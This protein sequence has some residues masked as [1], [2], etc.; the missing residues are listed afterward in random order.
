MRNWRRCDLIIV[1][2]GIILAA[3]IFTLFADKPFD[4]NQRK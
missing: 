2:V 4:R 1:A 3:L